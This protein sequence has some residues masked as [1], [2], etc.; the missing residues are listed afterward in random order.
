MDLSLQSIENK[1]LV[2]NHYL[3]S[4][5]LKKIHHLT[6]FYTYASD[7]VKWHRLGDN[8]LWQLSIDQYQ[9]EHGLQASKSTN[10]NG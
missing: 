4:A 5:E 10:M 7:T 8:L 6:E 1:S 2:E 9:I 3:V